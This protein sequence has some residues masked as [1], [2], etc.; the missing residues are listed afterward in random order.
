MPTFL[1]AFGETKTLLDWTRDPRCS[2]TL[3]TLLKRTREQWNSEEA[4]TAPSNSPADRWKTPIYAFGE[5]KTLREWEQ[6]ERAK[7]L[8]PLILKR[9]RQGWS[10]EEA[11]ATLAPESPL[12][13]RSQTQ[14]LYHGKTLNEL[15]RDPQC[16]VSRYTLERN[17]RA[18]MPL[19]E[20][21][22]FRKRQKS[23]AEV[24]VEVESI[25]EAVSLLQNGELWQ[26][27]GGS[28]PRFSILNDGRR[29]ELS[30]ELFIQ[31]L[32]K[33]VIRLVSSGET[34]RQYALC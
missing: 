14:R 8:A 31:M 7:A 26:Y 5:P 23:Q 19:E 18:H 17:L 32:Q 11:I 16:K 34:V 33:D 28:E 15:M 21:L 2:V 30:Q 27:V 4:L 29:F 9:L 12:V 24:S 25:E 3:A 20:A 6:D 1:T 13:R 10:P 22:V